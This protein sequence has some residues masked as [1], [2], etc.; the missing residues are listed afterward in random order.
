MIVLGAD[1][2]VAGR[3]LLCLDNNNNPLCRTLSISGLEE[4]FIP[5]I[6]QLLNEAQISLADIDKFIIGSGP[7]SFMGL[8]IGYVAFK[9]WAWAHKRPLGEISS[10]EIF[11]CSYKGLVAPSIDAKMGKVFCAIFDNNKR[12][13]PDSDLSPDDYHQL[14]AQYPNAK[15]L[16]FLG[17]GE[18]ASAEGLLACMHSLP[19]SAFLTGNA[20]LAAQPQYLRLSAAEEA[21]LKMTQEN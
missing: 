11:A 2:S 20:M 9:A 16:G 3:L 12:L 8:R 18:Q 5:T 17:N 14:L 13:V 19:E 4:D 15:P 10:L 7:G 6:Q 1:T 21:R